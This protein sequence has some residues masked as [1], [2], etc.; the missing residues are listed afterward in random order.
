[1]DSMRIPD[2]ALANPPQNAFCAS[3]S[4]DSNDAGSEVLHL[5]TIVDSAESSPTAARSAASI[6]RKQLDLKNNATRPYMQY[7]AI[8]LLRILSDNPGPT[9]TRNLAEP[10]FISAVKCLLREGKDPSVRQILG[11]TLE[12]FETTKGFDEGLRGLHELW[13][14]EKKKNHAVQAPPLLQTATQPPG[15]YW[16]IPPPSVG[17]GRTRPPPGLPSMSELVARIAEAQTSAS[18][19]SQLLQSTPQLEVPNNELV[20]E[21]AD[22]CKSASRS[23]VAYISADPPPDEDTL[24]TLIETNDVLSLSLDEWKKA[25]NAAQITALEGARRRDQGSRIVDVADVGDPAYLVGDAEERTVGAGEP[26]MGEVRRMEVAPSSPVSP[27]VSPSEQ[28]F[29]VF[30][31]RSLALPAME[32]YRYILR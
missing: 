1:M 10:K 14:K 4:P 29:V 20:R 2:R 12:Y 19:L 26:E 31:S 28:G 7:N 9:F 5:P 24:T 3:G 16:S 22:R 18:L 13:S 6:L 32:F 23:V 25:V 11:E 17:E 15:Q 27:V 8:M 30:S 21:F